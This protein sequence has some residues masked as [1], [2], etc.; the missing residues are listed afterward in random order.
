[1]TDYI[2]ALLRAQEPARTEDLAW[3]VDG[4]ESLVLPGEAADGILY[5]REGA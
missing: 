5:E 4:A 2:E 3:R 1:M